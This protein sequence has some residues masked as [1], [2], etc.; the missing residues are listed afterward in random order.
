M[1]YLRKLGTRD[2]LAQLFGVNTSTL[3]RAVHQV[4]PFLAEHSYTIPPS[5]ARFRMPA[6]VTAFLANSGSTK[7]KTSMLI[8]CEPL[9]NP[10]K[11]PG[12]ERCA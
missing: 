12:S 10:T 5:T 1:L 6:D 3:T 9:M 7:I 8:L 2:L 11:R 4:Q